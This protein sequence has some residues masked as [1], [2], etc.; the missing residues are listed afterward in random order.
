MSLDA[1]KDIPFPT[2]DRPFGIQLWPIFS[3]AFEKV[4]GYPAQD[5]RFVGGV[6]PISTFKETAIALV[7]YYVVVFGG[8]EVMK[9]LPAQK[10]NGLFM[11]HNFYLTT[12]SG[13]LLALFLE[14]LIPTL[15]HH[16]IFYSIC[17]HNGGWT[18]PLVTLYYVSYWNAP[19]S[20]YAMLCSLQKRRTVGWW[21]FFF[22]N[23][24]YSLTTWQN[25]SSS[26]ILFSLSWRRN[27][28]LS[29]T[30]IITE[31]PR[32]F[33]IPNW[34]VWRLYRGFPSHWISPF[35][36]LCTGTISRALVVSAFGGRS[37]LLSFKSFSSSS[38]LVNHPRTPSLL[39]DG[40]C[41]L[42]VNFL[43]LL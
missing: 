17:N 8:R 29:S 27:R 11:I 33:A 18:P 9:K 7:T 40:T 5:F 42:T 37:G 41:L 39:R 22:I 6:T 12:I 34:L 21:I 3:N 43:F 25:T 38:I 28:L 23:S 14:Q 4:M 35:M 2:I 32:S 15:Y 19:F 24:T 1:L 26:L 31:P 30:L 36:W 16:G 20:F 10:L 13:I